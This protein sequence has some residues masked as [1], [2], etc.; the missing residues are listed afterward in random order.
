MTT[1]SLGR[2]ASRPPPP[3]AA[4]APSTLQELL[5]WPRRNLQK[6]R[7]SSATRHDFDRGFAGA[8]KHGVA[9]STCYSGVGAPEFAAHLLECAAHEL[10]LLRG[11]SQEEG[12]QPGAGFR[13]RDAADIKP[14]ARSALLGHP[15]EF[16]PEHVFGDVLDRLTPTTKAT[17]EHLWEY[18]VQGMPG[19]GGR[20]SRDGDTAREIIA[21]LANG[22]STLFRHRR[23]R[24]CYRHGKECPLY[25]EGDAAVAADADGGGPPR[26][27]PLRVHIAGTTCKDFTRR[28]LQPRGMQG[29]HGLALLVWLFERRFVREDVVIL[30]NTPDFAKDTA[31]MV[32]SPFYMATV[33]TAGPEDF[34]W[35][36][37][38]RRLYMVFLRKDVFRTELDP[39]EFM[40]IFSA[41]RPHGPECERGDMFFAAPSE[42]VA[43]ELRRRWGRRHGPLPRQ[44]EQTNEGM[45]CSWVDTLTPP[46]DARRGEYERIL[47]QKLFGASDAGELGDDI[48]SDGI[49]RIREAMHA[50][51]NLSS[52]CDLE[53]NT[54]FAPVMATNCL[55]CLISHGEYF[56]FHKGRSLIGCEF[57]MAQGFP[58][59]GKGF[60]PEKFQSI[61]DSA[62]AAGSRGGADSHH[63][64]LAGNS[65]HLDVLGALLAWVLCRSFPSFSPSQ[66]SARAVEVMAPADE[67][68]LSTPAEPPSAPSAAGPAQGPLAKR[69]RSPSMEIASRARSSCDL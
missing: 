66:A 25:Q 63:K 44:S 4:C 16:A 42:L 29:R 46:Q 35:W 36:V 68:P 64:D 65:M 39:A 7:S 28:N 1:R 13:M 32:L 20:G 45:D 69:R 54:P 9:I 10:G 67:E 51:F 58:M 62:A 14:S 52:I 37:N 53:Q 11:A 34:G 50:S 24:H 30:E 6:L 59:F 56:S 26:A 22:E 48:G 17:L 38:R 57:W 2:Q 3:P 33:I 19:N 18:G 21:V 8:L 27:R 31:A 12:V 15:A 40:A 61:L 49:K 41:R 43:E 23:R 5:D 55:P 47:V 60:R